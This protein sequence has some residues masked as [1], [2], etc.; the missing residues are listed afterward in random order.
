MTNSLLCKNPR[1]CFYACWRIM[2]SGMPFSVCGHYSK[3]MI[4]LIILRASSEAGGEIFQPG[5]KLSLPDIAE[6]V[7]AINETAASRSLSE[8]TSTDVCI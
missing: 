1:T 6:M 5:I 4:R 7:S 2:C 8:T 3:T